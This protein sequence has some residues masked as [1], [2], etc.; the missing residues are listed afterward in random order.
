M[1]H[2]GLLHLHRIE[3]NLDED[4]VGFEPKGAR[5]EKIIRFEPITRTD[6]NGTHHY[7]RRDETTY[8]VMNRCPIEYTG[9]VRLSLPYFDHWNFPWPLDDAEEEPAL[10]AIAK[11]VM[12]S[13]VDFEISLV[14]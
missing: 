4:F 13:I 12:G 10:R 2:R 11:F 8:F 7:R 5:T 9:T 14:D 3:V 1:V 6:Q